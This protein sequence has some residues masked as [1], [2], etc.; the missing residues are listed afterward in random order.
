LAF[1]SAGNRFVETNSYI[2][3]PTVN[4]ASILKITPGGVQSTFFS[5]TSSFLFEA[6]ATDRLNNVFVMAEETPTGPSTIY[7]FTPGGMQSTFGSLPSVGWGLAFDSAGNLLA[8]ECSDQTIYKFTPD[9]TRSIFVGPTAFGPNACPQGGLA[10]DRFDNLFVA[11]FEQDTDSIFEFTPN[12]TESTF[13]TGLNEPRG[14]A[15]DRS[16]NLFVAEN[17][18]TGPGDI[19]KFTPGGIRT[20]FASGI[21][22]EGNGG[23]KWLAIQPLTPRPSPHGRPIPPL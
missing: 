20:V 8:A 5:M 6:L 22:Q 9:G 4:V 21:G 3:Y 23:P 16:G 19:L 7:K 1:D 13:A 12:G 2:T 15:F 11:V 10:F 14:L 18:Q 17:I